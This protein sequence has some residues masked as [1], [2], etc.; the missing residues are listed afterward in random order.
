MGPKENLTFS[1][2]RIGLFEEPVQG[3][4]EQALD[5]AAQ[6]YGLNLSASNAGGFEEDDIAQFMVTSSNTYNGAEDINDE[7]LTT[8]DAAFNGTLTPDT[9]VAGHGSAASTSGEINFN[10]YIAG[11][12]VL[13]LETDNNQVGVG[14]F[15]VQTSTQAAAVARSN[16]LPVR[17]KPGAKAKAGWKKKQ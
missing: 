12:S 5:Y 8:S 2:R 7:G 16:F 13:I 4:R 1:L 6:G 9:V 17:M 15:E 14:S 10:Y 3:T 11:P